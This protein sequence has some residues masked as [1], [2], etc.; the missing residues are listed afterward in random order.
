MDAQRFG[1]GDDPDLRARHE[2]SHIVIEIEDDGKGFGSAAGRGEGIGL[3]G[4]KERAEQ[5]GARLV[6]QSSPGSGTTVTVTV[7]VPPDSQG[8]SDGR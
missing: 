7:P 6:I 5:M 3:T 1:V 4:M 8:N 2:E